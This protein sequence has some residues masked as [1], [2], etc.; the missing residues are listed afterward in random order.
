MQPDCPPYGCCLAFGAVIYCLGGLGKQLQLRAH[1]HKMSHLLILLPPTQFSCAPTHCSSVQ[2]YDPVLLYFLYIRQLLASGSAMK[3]YF[4]IPSWQESYWPPSSWVGFRFGRVLGGQHDRHDPGIILVIAILLPL[5]ALVEA[6]GPV[7]PGR[8]AQ[9]TGH[10]DIFGGRAGLDRNRCSAWHGWDRAG[11]FG[12]P[13][14]MTRIMSVKNDKERRKA[15]KIAMS[16]SLIVFQAWLFGAFSQS[17]ACLN[18][19]CRAD[20]VRHHEP[21]V[22]RHHRR[23]GHGGI[24]VCGYV[25]G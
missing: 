9:D 6:G 11:T 25:N 3:T 10:L 23:T 21:A 1:Q 22:S 14:L 2:R 18:G 8:L 5:A 17:S 4:D 16:W 24:I 20:S 13:Q 7:E 15:F 12:Q 19:Q